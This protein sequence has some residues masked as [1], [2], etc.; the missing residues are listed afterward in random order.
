MDVLIDESVRFNPSALV[1]ELPIAELPAP[2]FACP[3]VARSKFLPDRG[4][5]AVNFFVEAFQRI[6]S[7]AASVLAHKLDAGRL[8]LLSSTH[9]EA[10]SMRRCG[11]IHIGMHFALFAEVGSVSRLFTLPEELL[12][13]R[14]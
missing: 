2:N 10:V 5:I 4:T 6:A 9:L 3:D 8:V 12:V 1:V 14:R 7:W 11:V 13:L